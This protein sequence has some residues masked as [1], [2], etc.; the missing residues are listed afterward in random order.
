MMRRYIYLLASSI[1]CAT[2]A[3]T[4]QAPDSSLYEPAM[5]LR[6]GG[7]IES[8]IRNVASLPGASAR[9]AGSLREAEALIRSGAGAGIAARYESGSLPPA[10]PGEPTAQFRSMDA[11]VLVG[12]HVASLALGYQFRWSPMGLDTRRLGL[13]RLGAEF[14]RRAEAI[15]VAFRASGSY[16]RTIRPDGLDS[17]QADG[18]DAETHVTYAPRLAPIYVDLGYRRETLSMWRPTGPFRREESSKLIFGI[19]LQ[20]GLSEK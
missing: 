20:Y 10:L 11:E 3:A 6:I 19:G 4:A 15:G 14:G 17:L 18:I 16:L 1:V 2:A 7:A 8:A 9:S 12:G 13:A 5:D